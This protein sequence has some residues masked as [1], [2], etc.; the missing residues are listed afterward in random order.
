MDEDKIKEDFE[1]WDRTK[2]RFG[3]DNIHK[4]ERREAFEV[5]YAQG[6]ADR[7]GT[8]HIDVAKPAPKP[9]PKSRSKAKKQ[10]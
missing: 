9:K 10:K 8:V 1:A 5:G 7:G 3:D 6:Y 2:I 4:R